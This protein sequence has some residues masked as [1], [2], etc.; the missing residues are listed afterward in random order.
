LL[1][2]TER[3]ARVRFPPPF[4]VLSFILVGIAFR[5]AFFPLALSSYRV[6]A[7]WVGIAIVLGA[8]LLIISAR[9][10]FKR[11]GQDPKPWKPSPSLLLGGPYQF[12]RNP[13]YVGITLIQLGLG[14]ALNNLWISLLAPL[15]L[16]V[17]HFM[18]VLP[19]E[20]YLTE[21]FGDEYK[22]YTQ[23]VHRYI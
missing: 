16:L 20:E 9:T 17:L 3:G 4:V 12:S 21:R 22:A 7:R 1:Q 14:L 6:V 11:S 19:E 23:K 18:A 10:L 13:M 8:L 5:Y 2:P 15:S